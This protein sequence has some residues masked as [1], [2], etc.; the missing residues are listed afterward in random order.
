MALTQCN[1]QMANLPC[2]SSGTGN[3]TSMINNEPRENCHRCHLFQKSIMNTE[4]KKF[5][6]LSGSAGNS[7][8]P[9]HGVLGIIIF[10]PLFAPPISVFA[11]V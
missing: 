4:L 5:F 3:G 2:L 1:H 9:V 11:R 6:K 8:S 10:E 7:A